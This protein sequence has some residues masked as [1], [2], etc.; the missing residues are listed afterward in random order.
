[1]PAKKQPAKKSPA[2][3]PIVKKKAATSASGV[4]CTCCPDWPI[5]YPERCSNT[6]TRAGKTHYFCTARC[7][8]KFV[9]SPEKYV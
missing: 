6:L 9:K 2:K 1:M 3:K 5:K 4:T 8:E 7:K